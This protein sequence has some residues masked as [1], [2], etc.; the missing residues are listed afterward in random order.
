MR[1]NKKIIFSHNETNVFFVK[2]QELDSHFLALLSYLSYEEKIRMSKLLHKSLKKRYAISHGFLRLL[3]GKYLS[4]FPSNV[5][6][7]YNEF[8]KPFCRQDPNLYFNM[9][10]S[11]N[12]I[13][14]VFSYNCKSG[15]DIECIKNISKIESLFSL[16]ASPQEA[17]VFEKQNEIDKTYFFYKTWTIKEAF[18]KALGIGLTHPLSDIE[19]TIIPKKRF[20][21]IRFDGNK[22]T[23]DGWTFMP[24]KFIPS[25]LGAVAVEK[26][27]EKIN[28]HTITSLCFS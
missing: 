8:K 27:N 18:L 17:L 5:E 2:L 1:F 21:V 12:Y 19:T 22:K 6:Y 14:Y 10:H 15:I 4:L 23:L 28:F 20:K 11:N 7:N 16:I 25:Y 3:L 24:I 13:F 9:S 26:K